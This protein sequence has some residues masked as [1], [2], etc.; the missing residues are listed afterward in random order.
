M[1][2]IGGNLKGRKLQTFHGKAIRPTPDRVREAIFNIL[3]HK[4]RGADVLDLFA[5]TGALGIESVSRGARSAVFIDQ[6]AAAIALLKQNLQRCNLMGVTRIIQRDVSRGLD[7]ID[8]FENGFNLVFLDPPYGCHLAVPALD[9]L[10]RATCL[11]PESTI[12]VEHEPGLTWPSLGTSISITDTRRY[13]R[14][15]VTF[16]NYDH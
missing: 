14:T 6:S 2:I 3:A 15:Q 7:R 11:R 8:N 9:L 4:P 1:R 16:M 12:V 10:Q 13:G 5:G